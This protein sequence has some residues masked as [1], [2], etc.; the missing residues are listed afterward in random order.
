MKSLVRQIQELSRTPITDK[1]KAR[2]KDFESFSDKENKDW[3]SELC[4]CILTANSKAITAINIQQELG[5]EGFCECDSE[6]VINCIIRNKHRFHN[7][8]TKYIIEAREYINIKTIIKD[9]IKEKGQHEAR[10]W[11]TKHV[12]GLG[13]KEA[14]HFSRNVGYDNLAILDRHILNLMLENSYIAE[15]S[16]TL[17]KKTYLETEKKF[18]TIDDKL[19]MSMAELDLYMWYLKTG[20]VL[21]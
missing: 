7:N 8:K 4:F 17:S 11:L 20:E 21:K 14:S 1:I 2:L 18:K 9:M 16:K 13:Y 15:I 6:G 10:E 12:K 3:F 5:P 19:D